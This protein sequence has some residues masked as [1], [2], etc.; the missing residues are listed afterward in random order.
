MNAGDAVR[1]GSAVVVFESEQAADAAVRA[2]RLSG[3]NDL[4]GVSVIARVHGAKDRLVG[5]VCSAGGFMFR[6]R[7][8]AFWTGLAQGAESAA[9]VSLPPFGTVA[10]LGPIALAFADAKN[11]AH[12]NRDASPI[13]TALAAAGI[14]RSELQRCETA[15]WANQVV[16]VIHPA[17]PEAAARPEAD[18]GRTAPVLKV[19]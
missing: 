12:R 13:T 17:S 9:L 19:V 8:G 15:L 2:M 7:D 3:T 5:L 10:A 6:G 18:D 1:A 4:R 14:P 16:L 11:A